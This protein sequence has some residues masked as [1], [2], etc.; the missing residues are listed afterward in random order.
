MKRKLTL[1]R[2]VLVELTTGEL[3]SVV[4]ASG[5]PC[6][7]TSLFPPRTGIITSIDVPCTT[8]GPIQ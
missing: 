7:P 1:R 6:D 4:G 5:L 3:G 2:E 8:N